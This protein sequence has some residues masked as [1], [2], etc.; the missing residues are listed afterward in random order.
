[1]STR[2]P[3]QL[4]TRHPADLTRLE[5]NAHFQR[6]EEYDQLVANIRRDGHLESVPLIYSGDGE[7]P[8]G[9]ELIV[10]GN[11]RCDASADAGLTEIHCLLI[12]DPLSKDELI[13]KQLSHN[14]LTGADD[15]AT[16]AQL[17]N[18]IEDVDWR[19]Y[20]GLD[21]HTLDL[22]DQ[23]DGMEGLSEANLDFAT[24]QLVFLPPELERAKQALEDAKT[25]ADQTWLAAR[26]DYEPMLDALTSAHNAHK[27][28]NVATALH[29]ILGIYENHLTDLQGGYLNADGEPTGKHPVGWESIFGTRTL[30]A[31]SAARIIK[32]LSAATQAGDVDPERPWEL[33]TRLLDGGETGE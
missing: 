13:A 3:P 14:A 10:S 4:V 28:G 26:A 16:L 24:V 8:E 22:L 9:R 2:T 5:V 31:D 33:I 18:R 15:P 7:Y 21:D 11:H 20:A 29:I 32:E 12:T 1:M 25:G 19:A 23:I 30:P 6:K 17:Y 27:V